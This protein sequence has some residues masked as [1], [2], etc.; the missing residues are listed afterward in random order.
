MEHL[1]H[2]VTAPRTRRE[3]QIL[4]RPSTARAG[5]VI[6]LVTCLAGLA[7]ALPAQVGASSETPHN[8]HAWTTKSDLRGGTT[9]SGAIVTRDGGGAVTLRSGT[10]QGTWTSGDFRPG[11]PT[12]QIVTSWQADTPGAA[13]IEM[14]LSVHVVDHWSKWYAMGNWA[15]DTTAI[16][17]TSVSGQ[18]D[19]DGS[20][21]VDTY[22][23]A[24]NPVD[25]YRLRVAL[26]GDGSG[27][28]TVRQVAA[29][30]SDPL[31]PTATTSQTT[32][33]STIQLAV[34]MYSQYLHSGEYPQFD[35]GGEAWCSPTSTEMVLEYWHAGPSAADLRTLPPDPVFDQHGRVDP[36]VDWAAVHTF[37]LDFFGTGNWPFNAA[38]AAHYGLDGSVRQ[39]AS[40][41][42]AERWIELG[43]P[44]VVSIN[45]DNTSSDPNRHL[46]GT[47]IEKTAG[48][49]MVLS[50]ITGTGDIIANDPASPDDQS[51]RHTYR[52]DQFEFRWQAASAGTAYLI[53]PYRIAG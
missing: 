1:L 18:D 53:K 43:V 5:R 11:F 13:W 34:P 19:A 21:S 37:D 25:A 52:R 24:T 33:T 47:S 46:D 7:L 51:V 16:Q 10:T 50:G 15:F 48:H 8:F 35:N 40:V 42:E 9:T 38:Y 45:W 2:V 26:H 12:S 23:S 14:Q 44:L 20:I 30:A 6:G 4:T 22:L 29:T 49:L 31:A 32:V 39:F 17:R 36:T 28:P 3:E 41:R 27:V